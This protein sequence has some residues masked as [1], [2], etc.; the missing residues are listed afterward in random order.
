MNIFNK[1]NKNFD[2]FY[3]YTGYHFILILLF[4]N[5]I[6][7]II[8]LNIISFNIEYI[9]FF[10][11][12]V[13]IILCIFLIIRFN[14]LREK[15]ELRSNDPKMIFIISSFLIFNMFIIDLIKNFYPIKNDSIHKI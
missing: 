7:F 1:F 12:T 2:K 9:N 10:H 11:N 5:I 8:L 4:F 13:N 15:H 14:P 6:Y 3:D